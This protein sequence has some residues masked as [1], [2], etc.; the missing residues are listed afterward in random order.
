MVGGLGFRVL[1]VALRRSRVRNAEEVKE[2]MECTRCGTC[3]ISTLI[4]LE[5]GFLQLNLG[6]VIHI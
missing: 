3:V 6:F 5:G 4:W 1:G 2:V